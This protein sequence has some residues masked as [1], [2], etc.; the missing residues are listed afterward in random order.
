MVGGLNTSE[1][2]RDPIALSLREKYKHVRMPN[3]G[4]TDQDA[5][6]VIEYLEK[7]DRASVA[8]PKSQP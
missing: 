2:E 7:R 6:A 5:V 1:A 3:P 8:A 4:L